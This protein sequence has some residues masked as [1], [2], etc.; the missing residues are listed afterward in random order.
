MGRKGDDRSAVGKPGTRKT[1]KRN[2]KRERKEVRGRGRTRLRASS[3]GATATA[4][5]A[6]GT[7]ISSPAVGGDF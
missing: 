3:L 4:H 5:S 2:K 7:V 1:K 6:A